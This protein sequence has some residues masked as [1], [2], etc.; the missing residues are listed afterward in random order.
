MKSMIKATATTLIVSA[1]IAMAQAAGAQEV[2]QQT[3]TTTQ[4]TGDISDLSGDSF[5]IRSD[6]GPVTY[7]YTKRTTVV[8]QD[9]RPLSVDVI[10]SGMPV[11][12]YYSRTGDNME[13][14]RVVVKRPAAEIRRSES[15]TTTTT[16]EHEHDH[17]HDGH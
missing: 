14:S 3:T 7:H 6:S 13:V 17:D 5:V 10:K 2:T 1:A 8:D 16:T 4:S 9:G 12:V 11:T 15:T